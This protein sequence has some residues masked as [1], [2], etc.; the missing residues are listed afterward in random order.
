MTV[1]GSRRMRHRL[2]A[3]VVVL[4]G[5]VLAAPVARG[6]EMAAPGYRAQAYATGFPENHANQ[7]GPIGIAFDQSDRLYVSDPV[8]GDIYRFAS[9][10]GSASP[11]T[12]LTR[13]P[14]PGTLSGLAFSRSGALYAGRNRAG[15]VV[16]VDP[17]TGRVLRTVASVPCATGLAVDPV[18]GDL[19]VSENQCGTTIWRISGLASRSATAAPYS[20]APGVDGLAFDQSGTLY[21]ESDG[22]ILQIDGTASATPG[23]AT[24]VAHVPRADGLA[25]GAHAS[26]QPPFL[27]ANRN[28]GVVTRVDFHGI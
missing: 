2:G 20:Y 15:D 27:V 10:G 23:M 24:A 14:I 16:Q 11:S 25:F 13:T 17:A 8:D 19:F 3:M 28:D 22:S 9:G 1:C 21:A 5:F 26:G 4:S 18:S 7:Q 6:A 12:R